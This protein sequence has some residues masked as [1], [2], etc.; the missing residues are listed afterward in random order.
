MIHLKAITG[1][2]K[3]GRVY[4]AHEVFISYAHEDKPIAD[5]VCVALESV[6]IGCWIAPRDISPGM[7]YPEAIISAITNCKVFV[8]V[9]SSHSNNSPHV[10]AET[11]KAMNCRIPMIPFRI[12]NIPLTPHMEYFIGRHQ[13]LDAL[14]SPVEHHLPKLMQAVQTIL[15][16]NSLAATNTNT[17]QELPHPT[18]QP[19][20]QVNQIRKSSVFGTL[21]SSSKQDFIRE[22]QDKLRLIPD[23]EFFDARY[24]CKMKVKSFF[25]GICPVTNLE[26]ERFDPKHY[27]KRDRFSGADDEPVIYVSW[28]DA[29]RYCKWLSKK[30]GW[31]FRLPDEAEWEYAC[32]AGSSG[33][34]SLDLDGV[35]VN[36]TNL[37][38]YAVYDAQR[39]LPVKQRTP[40]FFG[41]YDMHGNILEWCQNYYSNSKD[42]RN[43]RVLR[44]GMWNDYYSVS[45]HSESRRML[46]P[47]TRCNFAGFRVVCVT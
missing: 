47:F 6:R 20:H 28:D 19:I 15:G 17:V 37:K 16:I 46:E 41:L 22:E 24:Q 3:K 29:N 5:A 21:F 43:Y 27:E 40:N 30:I 39:T 31:T 34:Y 7:N 12:A 44:G 13:W 42:G 38:N 36:D 35:E 14:T 23:G 2:G 11:E 33:T 8:L 18:K 9:Y 4:M 1:I 10:L 45:L 25:I 32:R 26:Y